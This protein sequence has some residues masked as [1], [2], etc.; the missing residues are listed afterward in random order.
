MNIRHYL[1]LVGF[2]VPTVIIGYGFVIPRSCIAG[3][4]ELTIGFASSIVGACVT[5]YFG[6]RTL[7]SDYR[8]KPS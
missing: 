1:P 4:N 6:L 7:A 5:Y 2:V 8:P 3:V